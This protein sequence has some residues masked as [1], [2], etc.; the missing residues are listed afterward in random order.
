MQWKWS[1]WELHP[2]QSLVPHSG[3]S[4]GSLINLSS[5]YQLIYQPGKL[6]SLS[7]PFT[8]RA[9]ICFS[10]RDLEMHSV[11]Q[12]KG[13]FFKKKVFYRNLSVVLGAAESQVWFI[14]HLYNKEASAGGAVQNAVLWIMRLRLDLE[15]QWRE[16]K[17]KKMETISERTTRDLGIYYVLTQKRFIEIRK[18]IITISIAILWSSLNRVFCKACTATTEQRT[19]HFKLQC[20]GW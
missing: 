6:V 7:K 14:D 2:V 11:S 20:Y 16:K 19:R 10:V 12:I 1:Q 8:N 5:I 15:K 17:E 18:N 9:G 3:C 4:G 13:F